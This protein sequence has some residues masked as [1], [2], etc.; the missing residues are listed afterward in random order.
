MVTLS[1]AEIILRLWN[2]FK[3]VI[4]EGTLSCGKLLA[5]VVGITGANS[6]GLFIL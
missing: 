4:Q 3:L 5:V 1:D 2:Q 6:D